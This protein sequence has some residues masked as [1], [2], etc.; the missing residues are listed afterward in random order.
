[1]RLVLLGAMLASL[2]MSIA[3][4]G[5]FADKATLFAFSYVGLQVGRNVAGMVLLDRD[6]ALRRS[7]ERIVAWSLVT[8]V[9]WIAGALVPAGGGRWALW[10]LALGLDL[11]APLV[12]YATPRL[13]RS[14]TADWPVEGSHFAERFQAFIIIALG[15]SIVVAGATASA[16]G[17]DRGTVTGLVLAFLQ[18][19]TL[20]WLYFGEIAERAARR[21]AE[22]EDPGAL[23]RDAF[24][25]LHLPIVA[26]I[27]VAAV[28]DELVILHPGGHPHP[29]EVLV[30]IGGPAIY[31]IGES[32]V[33]LRMAGSHSRRR[34]VTVGAL[35]VLAAPATAMPIVAT[36]TLVTAVLIGLA[37]WEHGRV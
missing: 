15:E 5:A 14:G 3:I 37:A 26:G 17:L 34:L 29:A 35:A 19:A 20:W 2:L 9:P 32:L 23:A 11:V 31:L 10:G 30:L 7:F 12:G 4:P 28:G 27:I 1:V 16:A 18:T 6:A 22:S 36:Y 24:T 21:I 25:Y 13:G 8:S 33:R